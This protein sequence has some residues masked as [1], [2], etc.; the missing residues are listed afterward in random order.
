[1]E[2]V[3][4]EVSNRI[5]AN[6]ASVNVHEALEKLVLKNVYRGFYDI[7][8]EQSVRKP[9]ALM[10]TVVET[11]EALKKARKLHDSGL[12]PSLIF[13]A[14]D[15]EDNQIRAVMAKLHGGP[16]DDISHYQNLRKINDYL[17]ASQPF[18]C[19]YFCK[20]PYYDSE[21]LPGQIRVPYDFEM[22]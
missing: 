10:S 1:M 18:L 7:A 21:S 16:D 22:S 11:S 20:T 19:L 9:D 12:H 5:L 17:T 4:E 2:R 3:H 14:E 6:R 15:L 8:N 13:F